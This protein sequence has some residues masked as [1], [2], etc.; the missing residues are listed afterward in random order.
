MN[1]VRD[2]FARHPAVVTARLKI[3]AWR[4]LYL[5][6]LEFRV[7]HGRFAFDPMFLHLPRLQREM[8]DAKR[9]AREVV[10]PGYK[11]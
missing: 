9:V 5:R 11:L 2:I 10:P 3:R 4:E 1:V 7:R 6:C 8:L